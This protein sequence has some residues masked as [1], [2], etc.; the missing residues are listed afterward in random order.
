[1]TKVSKDF[2][3]F[4]QHIRTL[5]LSINEQYLLELFFEFHNHTYGYCYLQMKDI[6]VAFNTTSKNRV[7]TTIKNLEEKNLIIVDREHKNNRYFIADINSFITVKDETKKKVNVD[8]NGN[9][10]ADGQQTIEDFIGGEDKRIILVKNTVNS[11]EATQALITLALEN[12]VEIV[13]EA[14]EDVKAQTN[15]INSK[16]L[17]NAINYVKGRKKKSSNLISEINHLK[18]NNFEPRQYDYDKLEAMLNGWEDYSEEDIHEV[19]SKIRS[20][21]YTS[22]N[23]KRLNGVEIETNVAV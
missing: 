16:F 11:G 17:I 13:K 18:F 20:G 1:M 3:K 22:N 5:N 14:C 15:N 8:S 19:L 12:D 2:I 10:P 21:Y 23:S 6:L 7:S 4:R 9:T